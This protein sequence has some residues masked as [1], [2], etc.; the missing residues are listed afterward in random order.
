MCERA[1]MRVKKQVLKS[2][3]VR[4]V[5]RPVFLD[6]RPKKMFYDLLTFIT[7]RVAM[8]YATVP[9]VLLHLGPSLAFYG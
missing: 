8:T 3:Q 6:S 2:L 5:I 9:F 7:T 1:L 4:A